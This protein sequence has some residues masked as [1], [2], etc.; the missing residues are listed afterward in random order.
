M[1]EALKL[2]NW[3]S[4][5]GTAVISFAF[6]ALWYSPLLLGKIWKREINYDKKKI[7]TAYHLKSLLLAFFNNFA[8]V[9]LLA[10]LMTIT[11]LPA[12]PSFGV[13]FAV[14]A[15]ATFQSTGIISR[16]IWERHSWK[17]AL[18]DIGSKLIN[19]A[20]AGALLVL[21]H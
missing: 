5:L 10:Y 12:D 13:I 7:T 19:S 3:L 16:I 14:I 1:I 4:V 9:I 11:I 8:F 20:I 6:M 18:I 2:I 21:W 17:L 15:C